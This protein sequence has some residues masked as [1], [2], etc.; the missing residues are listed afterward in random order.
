MTFHGRVSP[1]E[2]FEAA[3]KATAVLIHLNSSPSFRMTLPSKL[4]SAFAAGGIVFAGVEGEAE[5]WVRQSGAGFTFSPG[6]ASQLVGLI[7]MIF[8]ITETE[9]EQL[10]LRALDFYKVNYEKN[11]LLKFYEE[12]LATNRTDGLS[13][14]I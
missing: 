10:T 4:A 12:L 2:A 5:E 3:K 13:Q 1:E 11:R 7:K 14:E 8:Q 6:N 9:Y